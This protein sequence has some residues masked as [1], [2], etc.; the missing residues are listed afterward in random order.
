[1]SDLEINLAVAT[2]QGYTYNNR[3]SVT[4]NNK[5]CPSRLYIFADNGCSFHKDYCNN[6]SDAWPIILEHKISVTPYKQD[7]TNWGW[8]CDGFALYANKD[9]CFETWHENPLRAAMIVFLKI[10]DERV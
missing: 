1:M 7:G 5:E 9:G 3:W 10:N 8:Q 6:P 4:H 2:I